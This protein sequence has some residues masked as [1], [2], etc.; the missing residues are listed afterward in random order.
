VLNGEF[1]AEMVETLLTAFLAIHVYMS[2][3]GFQQFFILVFCSFALKFHWTTFQQMQQGVHG[4]S[5][6]LSLLY[7]LYAVLTLITVY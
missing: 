6:A 5:S 7:T 1:I 2:G 4:V 3:M